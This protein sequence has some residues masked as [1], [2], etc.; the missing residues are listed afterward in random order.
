MNHDSTIKSILIRID[1]VV[2]CDFCVWPFVFL[3]SDH[4]KSIE[5]D[6]CWE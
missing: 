4:V 6:Y 3:R 5:Q 2:V 1:D